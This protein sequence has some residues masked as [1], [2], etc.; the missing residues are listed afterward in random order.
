V[1]ERYP[2]SQPEKVD[3]AAEREVAALKD[4]INACRALRSDMG[5]SPGQRVPLLVQGRRQQ[6]ASFAPYLTALARLSEVMI[7]ERELPKVDSPVSVVGEFKLMLKVE[8]DAAAERERLGK[9]VSRIEAEIA[10]AQAKVDNPS[11]VQRAP[12]L[13]VAQ[14]KERLARFTASLDKIKEQMRK[15]T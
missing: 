5:I 1:L 7:T 10:R 12:P 9:E 8:V 15:L 13:I 2:R 14:E 6:V 11:F 4:L 3:K